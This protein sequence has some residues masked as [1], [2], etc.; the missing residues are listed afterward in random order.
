M[1][2][3]LG[4]KQHWQSSFALIISSTAMEEAEPRNSI[5]WQTLETSCLEVS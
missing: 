3:N 2:C 4:W 5:S 1:N